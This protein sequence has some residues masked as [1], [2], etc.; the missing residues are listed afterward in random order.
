MTFFPAV[1]LI[2]ENAGS[3]LAAGL[4]ASD[5]GQTLFSFKQTTSMDSS[6]VTCMLAWKRHAKQRGVKLD[7]E[8]VPANLQSLI[9]LYGVAE[10]L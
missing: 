3:Q 9:V 5:D 2:H 10:L 7:F 1:Q 6:A 4:A 8:Q